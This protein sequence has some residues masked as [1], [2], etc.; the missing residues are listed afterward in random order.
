M[1]GTGAAETGYVVVLWEGEGSLSLQVADTKSW[2][3]LNLSIR[4]ISLL[5]NVRNN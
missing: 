3:Y 4:N 2:R 1:Q 5:K